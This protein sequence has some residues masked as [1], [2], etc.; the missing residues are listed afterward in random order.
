M[1][2]AEDRQ[3]LFIMSRLLQQV[4]KDTI[5]YEHSSVYEREQGYKLVDEAIKS[6]YGALPYDFNQCLIH[7][8]VKDRDHTSWH[9]GDGSVL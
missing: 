8:L 7:Y 4:L 5:N 2:N 6:V 1:D 9:T 3:H